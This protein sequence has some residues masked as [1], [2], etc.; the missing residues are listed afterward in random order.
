MSAHR[1]PRSS[2]TKGKAK[3]APSSTS[4]LPSPTLEAPPLLFQSFRRTIQSILVPLL[5]IF[6]S[7]VFFV[8]AIF[9]TLLWSLGLASRFPPDRPS[10]SNHPAI[11]ATGTSTGIGRSAVLSL[12][13]RGFRVFAGVR[14]EPD[15]ESLLTEFK[16][17][18]ARFERRKGNVFWKAWDEWVCG[19]ISGGSVEPVIVDVAKPGSLESARDAIVKALGASNGGREPSLY[20]VF[21]NAGLNTGSALELESV[22]DERRTLDVNL[23][24]ALDTAR[25]FLPLLRNHPRSARIIFTGS[26]AGVMT[27]PM[28]GIYCSSKFGLR[29]AAD[30]ARSELGP[31]GVAVSVLEPGEVDTDIW[32]KQGGVLQE[33]VRHELAGVCGFRLPLLLAFPTDPTR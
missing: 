14:K 17:L 2:P 32:E 1:G 21:A 5:F 24:G 25:V 15:G 28:S 18:Q 30:A 19:Y 7:F 33:M 23:L 20:A 10:F 26:L 13:S 16:R 12:A 11:F 4:A 22:E 3:A 31:L 6:D 8:D 9:A 27:A 29:A